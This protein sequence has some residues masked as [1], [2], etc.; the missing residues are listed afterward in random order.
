MKTH[1]DEKSSFQKKK[2][3]NAD[4]DKLVMDK[5]MTRHD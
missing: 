1:K 3:E 4:L 2:V 5:M